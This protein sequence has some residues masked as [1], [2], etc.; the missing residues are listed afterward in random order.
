MRRGRNLVVLGAAALT[1]AGCGGNQHAERRV[2][3]AF[4]SA[5][6]RARQ[7]SPLFPH[8]S[9]TIAC[10]IQTG[11]GSATKPI[12]GRCSTDISL[13]KHDRAVVTLTETWG[14]GGLAHTW[15]FFIHRN[16]AVLSVVQEGAPL[17]PAGG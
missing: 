10:T 4:F 8:R 9:G 12:Q 15:F 11:G 7:L 13:V 17:P 14:S 2:L 16:G 5:S 3:A 6:P 1:L